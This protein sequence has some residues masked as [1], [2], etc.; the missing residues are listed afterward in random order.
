MICKAR[1]EQRHDHHGE[2]RLSTEASESALPLGR[3]E[4]ARRFLEARNVLWTVAAGVLGPRGEIE[5]VLHD[6]FLAAMQKLDRFDP[7]EEGTSL[8]AW[9]ATFVRN[10]GRNRG[11]KAQRR[12]TVE[13]APEVVEE[14]VQDDARRAPRNGRPQRTPVDRRGRLTDLQEDFDDELIQA[15]ETL[16]RDARECLLL[17]RVLDLGYAEI[18]GI[19]G[20]PEGTAMSHV[21]RA[22]KALREHFEGQR[23]L[24]EKRA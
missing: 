9:M 12:G 7:T 4:F 17:K 15:L 11:R 19:L 10:V 14:L 22:Q 2:R 8:V 18:A 6:A 21:S 1:S 23:A 3:E 24:Q 16:G 20:I 5:D 13:V